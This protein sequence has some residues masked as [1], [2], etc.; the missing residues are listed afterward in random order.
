MKKLLKI[1]IVTMLLFAFTLALPLGDSFNNTNDMIE[2]AYGPATDQIELAYGPATDQIEL[3]YGPATDQIELA[4]GPATDQ[5]EL[6]Y[7]NNN[8]DVINIA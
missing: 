5:I 3:A 7:T 2:T 4:Y 8:F 6:A 1:L